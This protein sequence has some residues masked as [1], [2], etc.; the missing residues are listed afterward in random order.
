M[1]PI[2][3][4]IIAVIIATIITFSGSF[5]LPGQEEKAVQ[6]PVSFPVSELK[7]VEEK[8]L[9][10]E[11]LE[12]KLPEEKPGFAINTYITSGPEK[13]EIINETNR[14]VF[15]F[16]A[17]VY[18][19]E[20]QGRITYETKMQNFDDDWKETSSQ[21]RIIN[22]PPGPKEYTFL[23]RAKIKDVVDKTPAKRTFQINTSPYFDKV[24][25]SSVRT[26]TSSRSSLITL[27][28]NLEKEQEV[29]ITG[30]RIKGR[31]GSFIIPTGIEK[32]NPYYNPVP[33][34]DIF[35]KQGDKIYLSGASNP[36]GRGRNFRPN[37]C[38]GYLTNYHDFPVSLS[39][40][41]PKPAD[42]EISHLKPCCKVFIR[43]LGRCEALEYADNISVSTDAECTAYLNKTFNYAACY[44]N[45][46]RDEDFIEK[47]WHIYMNTNFIVSDDCDTLYLR[48]QNGLVIDKYDYGSPVCR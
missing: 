34:T 41:C 23:V 16:K 36:L 12:E 24:K 2:I 19:E 37:K 6:P 33:N 44:R 32:Y 42:E 38:L 14:V 31:I 10:K 9:E 27:Y 7:P 3:A 25:I 20:T 46:F 39:L 22:L 28:T 13:G 4:V 30:L 45:Y 35:I 43:N 18:P 8:P 5:Q 48:D 1:F 11:P 21:K 15:E 29:N 40:N 26:Q 47:N 17:K